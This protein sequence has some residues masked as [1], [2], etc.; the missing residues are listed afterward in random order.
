MWVICYFTHNISVTLSKF[1]SMSELSF[2]ICKM[3]TVIISSLLLL[4]FAKVDGNNGYKNLRTV[5]GT[6]D[7]FHNS[8]VVVVIIIIFQIYFIWN[9]RELGLTNTNGMFICYIYC[10]RLLTCLLPS[11]VSTL[12]PSLSL[13]PLHFFP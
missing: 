3:R 9:M 6:W 4:L 1:L 7:L 8:I 11:S 12:P 2:L 10:G 13:S 5:G